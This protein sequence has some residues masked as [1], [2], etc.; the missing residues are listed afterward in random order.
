[1]FYKGGIRPGGF[2]LEVASNACTAPTPLTV[3][4]DSL[5]G[6][7]GEYFCVFR[8]DIITCEAYQDFERPCDQDSD[9]GNPGLGDGK[10]RMIGATF[11]VP[12]VRC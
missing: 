3:Q 10:C 5:S 4:R 1:M 6:I 7:I 8:E 9:C 2:C 12:D 11:D